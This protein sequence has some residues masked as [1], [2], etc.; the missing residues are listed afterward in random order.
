VASFPRDG[1]FGRRP[2]KAALM[3]AG[4]GTGLAAEAPGPAEAAAYSYG[5]PAGF[6]LPQPMLD[7]LFLT[8]RLW[9][10]LVEAHRAHEDAKAAIWVSDPRV[11]AAQQALDAVHEAVDAACAQIRQSREED[12]STVPREADKRALEAAGQAREAAR[13]AR[14]AARKAARPGLLKEFAAAKTARDKARDDAAG[15]YAALG[16]G[17]GTKADIARPGGRFDTA[18]R[19][20]GEARALGQAAD[21][22][23]RRLDGTGTLVVKL[24]RE[25][26]ITAAELERIAELA[27]QGARPGDAAA[28][29]AA[30]GFP[31]RPA[32]AVSKML[33]S[34]ASGA[35]TAPRNGDPRRSPELLASGAGP[36]A[37]VAVLQPWADPVQ[38]KPKGDARH[39]TLRLK[40]GRSAGHGPVHAVIP[41]VLDRYLPAGADVTEIR[42]TRFREGSAVRCRVSV[43]FR[44]PA[45]AP[46]GGGSAGLVAVRLS[47][48]SAGEGWV[49]VAHV[50]ATAPLPPV[51]A[52][53]AHIVRVSEDRRSAEV[54]YHPDWRM[55]LD[56]DSAIQSVRDRNLD[57]LRGKLAAVLREDGTLAAALGV[58]PADAQRWQS[59]RR[60]A[61]LAAPGRPAAGDPQ[62]DALLERITAHAAEA[63]QWKAAEQAWKDTRPAGQRQAGWRRRMLA[64]V[65]AALGKQ[66]PARLSRLPAGHPV[67]VL[68]EDWR[69]RDRHLW[70]YGDRERAQVLRRRDDAYRC[71]AKW[72]TAQASGIVIDG[73]SLATARR[74]PGPAREDPEAARGA[75]RLLHQAAPGALR[76][77]VQAAAGRRKV[78]VTV[79]RQEHAPGRKEK[80]Q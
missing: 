44:A 57:L 46:E 7:Q 5:C 10:R 61:R 65:S 58:T 55:L 59:P 71:A 70:D 35:R 26:G 32:T 42:V 3:T 28:A 74:V 48:R 76:S 37:N 54:M 8:G 19:K 27:A 30:G 60:Y 6:D 23:F 67:A 18:V 36:W 29:L 79:V 52:G 77:A 66:R 38:G 80:G 20:V 72:L 33:K 75:R 56:R 45:C 68:L 4:A 51:P 31:A 24:I 43:G 34:A 9:N 69:H 73:T 47:W 1:Q 14:D 25:T 15:E 53:A 50:G 62:D 2:W 41:V 17:W 13:Q 22:R 39:G 12:R 21:L 11:A 49:T 78:P 16:L 63:A 40:A 64:E